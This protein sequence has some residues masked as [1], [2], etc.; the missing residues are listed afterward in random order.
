M[1]DILK[2]GFVVSQL[3]KAQHVIVSL[4]DGVNRVAQIV[5]VAQ[6]L[7]DPFYRTIRGL[8]ML[9]EKE[10]V[11]ARHAFH[12]T[13]FGK[14]RKK[15]E[16]SPA[17]FLQFLDCVWQLLTYN[18]NKILEKTTFPL[19]LTCAI[20]GKHPRRSSS[21]KN[22]SMP[23]RPRPSRG[24]TA[25]SSTCL[26]CRTHR[27]LRRPCAPSGRRCWPRTG[28]RPSTTTLSTR[29]V[30]SFLVFLF[31]DFF[32]SFFHCPFFSFSQPERWA[33]RPLSLSFDIPFLRLWPFHLTMYTKNLEF[34]QGARYPSD[35][36]LA[37][38]TSRRFDRGLN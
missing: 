26:S 30:L 8:Q 6:L 29:F 37:K 9:I 22:T 32:F 33:K 17:Y 18:D 12:A 4:E 20:P 13:A 14:G 24:G 3:V 11:T 15:V 28:T 19:S 27:S 34:A 21:T 1:H 31:V 35:S 23:S 7:L 5:S 2:N 36:T 16:S 25:R 10:W 38:V